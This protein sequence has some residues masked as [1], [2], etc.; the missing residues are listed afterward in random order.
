MNKIWFP[1]QRVIRTAVQVIIASAT[2]LATAVLVAPQVL[3]A[4]QE[5]LPGPV[6]IWIT[7]AIASL[8]A[9][10]AA[11]SRVMAIPAVDAWLK[12]FGAGSAPAGSVSYTTLGGEKVGLTR[13][14]WRDLQRTDSRSGDY[15]R[16]PRG[17][18]PQ[19]GGNSDS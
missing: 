4:V 14:Q 7:G 13:A 10:S 19:T 3:E 16:V 5:V 17:M 1:V 8:T 12:S 6:V 2:V 11:L 9:V 18:P 15:V